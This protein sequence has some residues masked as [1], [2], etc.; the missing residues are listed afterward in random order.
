MAKEPELMPLSEG[1]EAIDDAW[2]ALQWAVNVLNKHKFPQFTVPLLGALKSI[3]ELQGNSVYQ[4]LA[5]A[6]KQAT[7][8]TGEVAQ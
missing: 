7:D 8:E 5:L 6:N 4:R 1:I 2:Y 3:A